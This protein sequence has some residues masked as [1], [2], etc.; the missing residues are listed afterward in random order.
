MFWCQKRLV[1]GY[2]RHPRNPGTLPGTRQEGPGKLPWSVPGPPLTAAPHGPARR[3]RTTRLPCPR[4]TL[5]ELAHVERQA[6]TAGL[7]TVEFV[8]RLVLGMRVAPR[9]LRIEDAAIVE[10]IHVGNNLNQMARATNSGNPPASAELRAAL[11][12]LRGVLERLHRL[13]ADDGA[14]E[15]G[16]GGPCDGP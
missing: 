8:R 11:A 12:Q 4:V 3:Q 10:L 14:G 5:A 9:R 13:D 6:L 16:D 2:P 1:R 15:R 7:A